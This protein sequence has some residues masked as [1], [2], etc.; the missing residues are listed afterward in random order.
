MTANAWLTATPVAHRGLHDAADGAPENSLAAI[1]RAIAQGFAI[2]VDLRTAA[3]GIP[4][5]FHDETLDRMTESSGPLRDRTAP[6]LGELRLA[7]SSET[8]PTVDALLKAVS[9]AVPLFL[10]IKGRGDTARRLVGAVS[11][12]LEAYD[13]LAA[14][15][16]FDPGAVA[17]AAHFAPGRPNGLLSGGYDDDEGWNIPRHRRW[18]LRHCLPAL[19]LRPAFIGYDVRA[20]PAPATVLARRLGLPILTWTVRTPEERA[21]ARQH[22]DQMIFENFVPSGTGS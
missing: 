16:S 15:M 21:R 9:G 3:D 22:A 2:E 5:V 7:G 11:S 6:R 10:E 4:V 19:S 12:R 14:L 8:I 13:G 18:W 1:R 17:A 20:L